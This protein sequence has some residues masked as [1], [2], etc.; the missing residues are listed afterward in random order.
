MPPVGKEYLCFQVN[1]KS[2]HAAQ[3]VKSRILNKAID[4]I[5]YIDTFEQQRV[6]IKFMLQSSRPEDHMNTIGIDKSS[7]TRSSFEHKCMKNIKN[8][9]QHA[10]KSD[11]KQNLKDILESA[12]LS[13]PEGVINNSPNMHMISSPVKKSSARKSLCLFTNILDVKPKTGKRFFVAAKSKRRS[14]KLGNIIWTKNQ[15]EKGIQKSMSR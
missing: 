8:I 9:Y 12:L 1:S 7:F 6:V 5:L 2:P 14:M 15:N 3:C 13:T 4:S 11:D 10:G